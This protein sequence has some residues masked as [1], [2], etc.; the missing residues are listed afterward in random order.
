MT[1]P[2][3]GVQGSGLKR[4]LIGVSNRS[5][6][7]EMRKGGGR[8]EGERGKEREREGKEGGRVTRVR[9]IG[10]SGRERNNKT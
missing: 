3:S 6:F 10:A 2:V 1:K 4:T 7:T 5:N 9:K 8:N